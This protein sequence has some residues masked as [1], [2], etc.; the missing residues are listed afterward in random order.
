MATES[1][2]VNESAGLECIKCGCRHFLT[3]RTIPRDKRIVRRK[4]CRYCGW[5]TN[6]VEIIP[7]DEKTDE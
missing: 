1:E 7:D 4:E 2:N 6:T 3:I 5:R